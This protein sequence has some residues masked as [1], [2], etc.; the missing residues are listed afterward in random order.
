MCSG[1]AE[2][3]RQRT[4]GK[5][6]RHRQRTAAY[7]NVRQRAQAMGVLLAH[8]AGER[9]ALTPHLHVDAGGGVVV[10]Q[11]LHVCGGGA[12][13]FAGI[14]WVAGTW[15]V[16]YGTWDWVNGVMRYSLPAG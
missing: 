13:S 4:D 6:R 3:S 2:G 12:R 1:E 16:S 10:R 8:S 14:L 5:G 11:D 15:H 9:V 7:D